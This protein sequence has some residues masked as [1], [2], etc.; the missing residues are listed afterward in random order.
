MKLQVSSNDNPVVTWGFLD[1]NLSMA[2]T[3]SND[4]LL[5]NSMCYETFP[6]HAEIFKFCL[7]S[8]IA[9]VKFID[10]TGIGMRYVDIIE[11]RD[12]ETLQN[13]LPDNFIPMSGIYDGVEPE[14]IA[15]T[16][17]STNE[18]FLHVRCWRQTGKPVPDDLADQGMI[19]DIARQHKLAQNPKQT[20]FKGLSQ[21]TS[22]RGA[23]L[24]TDAFRVINSERLEILQ[25]IQQLDE[26]HILANYAFRTVCKPHAFDVWNES[27]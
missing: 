12:N 11:P 27:K 19:F 24:D 2:C 9:E 7:E 4:V 23:L 10:V 13:Y 26:L 14:G 20:L 22:A 16:T 17:Y 1:S 21:K 6:L 18:A 25:V 5:L 15:S 8:L 3:I